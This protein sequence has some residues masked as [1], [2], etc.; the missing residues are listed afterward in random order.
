MRA[1]E[2]QMSVVTDNSLISGYTN[3]GR[4]ETA[5]VILE[6]MVDEGHV[7]DV[8]IDYRKKNRS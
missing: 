2:V 7:A 5:K 1:K 8:P 4:F 6:E 3:Q